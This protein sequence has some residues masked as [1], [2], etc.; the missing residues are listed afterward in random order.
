[1]Q[2][3]TDPVCK[4]KVQDDLAAIATIILITGLFYLSGYNFVTSLLFGS[5]LSCISST[6]VVSLIGNL[7]VSE[8]TKTVL[9]IES[10]M[11]DVFSIV[12]AVF[13]LKF[14]HT[15]ES[16]VAYFAGSLGYHLLIPLASAVIIGFLWLLALEALRGVLILRNLIFQIS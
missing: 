14:I 2:L 4:M 10:I 12:L 7:A 11:S 16:G 1:M 13:L 5:A 8:E 3:H 15:G 9:V 6:I